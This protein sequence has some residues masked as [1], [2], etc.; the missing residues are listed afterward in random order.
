MGKKNTKGHSTHAEECLNTQGQLHYDVAT[1]SLV[2]DRSQ[3]FTGGLSGISG[4]TGAVGNPGLTGGT[5]YTASDGAY[6][7]H[8]PDGSSQ[9]LTPKNKVK[10]SLAARTSD[11]IASQLID[12]FTI[13]GEHSGVIEAVSTAI[14]EDKDADPIEM[15]ENFNKLFTKLTD[16][17]SRIGDPKSQVGDLNYP[18]G[19]TREDFENS[20]SVAIAVAFRVASEEESDKWKTHLAISGE[21]RKFVYDKYTHLTR[22][23]DYFNSSNEGDKELGKGLF[24]NVILNGL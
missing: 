18:E 20:C 9:W 24:V 1:S 5:Y 3:M 14:G 8:N 23:L 19:E 13:G 17:Y 22:M 6:F 16:I 21:E 10:G 2:A 15:M 4:T 7:M 11:F 12:I